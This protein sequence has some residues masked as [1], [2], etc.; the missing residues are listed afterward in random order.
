MAKQEGVIPISGAIGNLQFFKTKDGN[1]HVKQKRNFDK[2]RLQK[3]P[4]YKRLREHMSE[5]AATAKGS[6]LL[7]GAINSLVNRVSDKDQQTRLS[8]LLLR[9]A[10]SDKLNPRGSRNIMDGDLNMLKGFEFSKTGTVSTT[11]FGLYQTMIDRASGKMVVTIPEFTPER[12]VHPAPESTHFQFH[13]AALSINFDTGKFEY[14]LVS[15]ERIKWNNDRIN[16]ISLEP[17]V[18]ANATDP[19]MLLFGIEFWNE[20]NGAFYELMNRAY[21]GVVV[22]DVSRV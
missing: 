6:K 10:K 22:A 13:A 7:R 5:F 16:A 3:D 17:N 18:Q 2:A 20:T 9:I 4:S 11:Y 19:V 15:S 8:T 21:N 14:N 1:F 12:V